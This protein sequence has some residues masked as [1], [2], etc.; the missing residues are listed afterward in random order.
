MRDDITLAEL[1]KMVHKAL[2]SWHKLGDGLSPFN[3]LQFFQHLRLKESLSNS[4]TTHTIL[5]LLLEALETEQDSYAQLLT[6]HFLDQDTMVLIAKGLNVGEAQVYRMQ[7]EAIKRAAQ[8]LYGWEKK[9]QAK[10][11][12]VWSERLE[13]PTYIALIG[14]E[15]HLQALLSLLIKAEGPW[16][17]SIEGMGGV[18][19]TSLS[20]A[21]SRR[22]IQRCLFVD[23]AWVSAR[24]DD[25]NP[26]QGIK[27][28]DKPALT[29]ER[30]IERL[31]G[32]LTHNGSSPETLLQPERMLKKRLKEYPHLIV[33]DNLETV[34]DIET[35]LPLL[36]DLCNP[37]KFLL[38]SRQSLPY[39]HGFY[40]FPLPQLSET[41]ALHL[42]RYQAESHNS[43]YL[44]T[45]SDDDLKKIYRI[46]GG[47]PLAIRLVVGQ[48]HVY[49][50]D[51]IL[52]NLTAAQ[53]QTIENLYNFIYRRAWDL[54]DEVARE[55]L[56]VMPL[57]AEGEGDLAHVTE[58]SGLD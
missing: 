19:K 54:L 58:I 18:G 42:L 23:F 10:Q 27:A 38:T 25:F 37:T 15:E 26:G 21:L 29:A 35:L 13:R 20:D 17:I 45:S 22:V 36:R 49:S 8:I 34:L 40:H 44:Q 55:I 50:L 33:I 52:D 39:E 24:Q 56:L 1:Q 53:G 31:V 4:Q 9:S 3:P 5:T 46:V 11:Q 48:T 14:V 16:L 12:T 2:K 47:N 6:R 30:L 7:K 51:N 41:D 28:V 57:M 43:P 32:Q